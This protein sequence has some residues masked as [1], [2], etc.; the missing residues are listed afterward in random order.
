ME[1]S[2]RII[3]EYDGQMAFWRVEIPGREPW[4]SPLRVKGDEAPEFFRWLAATASRRTSSVATGISAA[5]WD[6][7]DLRTNH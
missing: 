6:V 5:E 4:H 2:A 3:S 1:R 7:D